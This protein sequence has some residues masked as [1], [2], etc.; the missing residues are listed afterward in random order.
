M[1]LADRRVRQFAARP[2]QKRPAAAACRR[3]LPRVLRSPIG[4]AQV[5]PPNSWDLTPA[6]RTVALCVGLPK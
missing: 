3:S 2:G 5:W 1:I 4:A 6:R